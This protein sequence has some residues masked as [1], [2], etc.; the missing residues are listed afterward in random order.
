MP[1]G[2]SLVDK[3]ATTD[4]NQYNPL[5]SDTGWGPF[6]PGPGAGVDDPNQHWLSGLPLL[7]PAENVWH[8][9]EGGDYF[10]FV[11][12]ALNT[13]LDGASFAGSLAEATSPGGVVA[14]IVQPLLAWI[15]DH[16]KPLRL[17]MDELVGNSATVA[18]VSATWANM[19]QA[20]GQAA[21]KYDQVAQDTQR[22]WRGAAADAYRK[23]ARGLAVGINSIGL[24]CEIWAYLLDSVSGMVQA[25]HDL[26]RDLISGLEAEL[27]G[28]AAD[29][30]LAGP[31]PADLVAM[32]KDAAVYLAEVEIDFAKMLVKLGEGMTKAMALVGSILSAIQQIATAIK[33]LVEFAGQGGHASQAPR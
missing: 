20:L 24:L 6:M 17:V 1:E 16:L 5:N 11:F 8:D 10:S 33:R 25:A 27:I 29:A 21:D 22:Y 12:D 9:L 4:F 31:P 18:G 30:V 19:G 14:T 23:R 7:A 28:I 3:N 32:A 26:A 15:M 13:I 2:N